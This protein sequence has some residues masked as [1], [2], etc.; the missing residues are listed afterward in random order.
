MD[1]IELIEK[2]EILTPEKK[3]GIGNWN[4]LNSKTSLIMK[5]FS[6]QRLEC[7]R[8]EHLSDLAR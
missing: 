8:R 2:I 5:M 7:A 1:E 3:L 4:Y 6:W